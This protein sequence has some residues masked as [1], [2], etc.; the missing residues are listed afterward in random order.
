MLTPEDAPDSQPGILPDLKANPSVKGKPVWKSHNKKQSAGQVRSCSSV[1]HEEETKHTADGPSYSFMVQ[2]GLPHPWPDPP[3]QDS[4][5]PQ[6]PVG[7]VL[8]PPN[9]LLPLDVLR[10]Q[11]S[12]VDD[13]QQMAQ[14]GQWGISASYGLGV[15]GGRPTPSTGPSLQVQYLSNLHSLGVQKA[16]AELTWMQMHSRSSAL[17]SQGIKA[18]GLEAQGFSPPSELFM[19]YIDSC[20]DPRAA[21]APGGCHAWCPVAP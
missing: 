6:V 5:W 21:V 18:Q 11:M 12:Q 10:Q 20:L 17:E 9:V 4:I 3:Q 13:I 15:I 19:P 2:K 7:Y 1:F 16:L 14:A 8:V